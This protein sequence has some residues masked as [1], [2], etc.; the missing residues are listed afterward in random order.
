MSGNTYLKK[1]NL[2]DLRTKY[3]AKFF[4]YFVLILGL[5]VFLFPFLWMISGSFMGDKQIYSNPPDLMPN[6]FEYENFIKAFDFLGWRSYL[7]TTIISGSATVGV[8]LLSS[9]C[10]FALA[11]LKVPGKNIIFFSFIIAILIP[12]QIALVP[13]FVIVTK[14][15]WLN[16]YQGAILPFIGT[17]VV[18]IYFFR[19]YF[20]SIPNDLFDAAKIDG[21]GT[22]GTFFR[23]LV[24]L[25]KPA[26]ST[27][28]IIT[29]L[30]V[31]NN[32]MWLLV[33][34]QTKDMSVLT[35]RLAGIANPDYDIQMSFLIAA[36]FLSTIPLLLIYIFAQRWFIEGI[37]SQG[38][39]N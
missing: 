39:K 10:G 26:F 18:Q 31:W 11:K 23:V 32:F 25:S 30:L 33:V 7:N 2:H 4:V 36:G 13:R 24:P 29:T 9:F 15:G 8:L 38:L 1:T 19:N 28:A 16:T 20:S 5:I 27:M 17:A 34:L 35:V 14:L 22:L 3:I 37:G 6:P 21:C 12:P